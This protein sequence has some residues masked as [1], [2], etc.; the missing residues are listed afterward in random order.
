MNEMTHEELSKLEPGKETDD[1]VA[2]ALGGTYARN[3]RPSIQ[4]EH[5]WQLVIERMSSG[6]CEALVNDD[7]GHWALADGGMQTGFTPGDIQTAFFIEGWQW[8]DTGEMAICKAIIGES[9]ESP[10]S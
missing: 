5:A 8:A 2:E 4:M 9:L 1:L 6:Y 3:W 7:D 10:D